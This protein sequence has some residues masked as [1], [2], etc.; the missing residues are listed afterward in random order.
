MLRW[1]RSGN[2]LKRAHSN[3]PADT[4]L[5]NLRYVV[6]DT[7]FTSLDKRSNR[8][9]SIGAIRMDGPKI[10]LGEQFYR[11]L[12]PGVE[13][14]AAT[15]VVHKL[16]PHDVEQAEPPAGV[17]ADFRKFAAGSV[18]VGHFVSMDLEVLG[19]ELASSG[20]EL[21]HPEVCTAE[22]HRWLLRQGRHTEDLFH[23][24]E[25][26]DLASLAKHYKIEFQET[27]HA[28]DDAF[29]TARLWQKLLHELERHEVRTLGDLMKVS[30]V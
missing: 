2:S 12:N 6:L 23:R 18:L 29:A 21:D 22:V 26:V 14:P 11:V 5:G 17:M 3:F 28:L 7:E 25:N 30:C 10:R 24:L 9:L 13:V 15:V 4:P 19:K 1:L 16:R 8:L 27:H 20:D